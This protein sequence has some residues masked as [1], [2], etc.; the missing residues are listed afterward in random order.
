M[1][2]WFD[3]DADL[4]LA[5]PL[6]VC[7]LDSEALYN[8]SATMPSN[9]TWF[10]LGAEHHDLYFHAELVLELR[11]GRLGYMERKAPCDLRE[12][13]SYF[14]GLC[15]YKNE[16]FILI[17]L[18][19]LHGTPD[20]AQA[21]LWYHG[22]HHNKNCYDLFHRVH[23]MNMQ[24]HCMDCTSPLLGPFRKGDQCVPRMRCQDILLPYPEGRHGVCLTLFVSLFLCWF[25]FHGSS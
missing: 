9:R 17:L 20:M 18:Y 5:L 16:M 22:E 1:Q 19:R 13:I 11:H 6:P 25:V 2:S 4:P 24:T 12:H 21:G 7:R 3:D 10:S 23:P 14:L 8:Q 15:G